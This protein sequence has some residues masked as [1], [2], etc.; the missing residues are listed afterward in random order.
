MHSFR[1]AGHTFRLIR[2]WP[3]ALAR[4]LACQQT[5]PLPPRG[6]ALSVNNQV[7]RK[8]LGSMRHHVCARR[9]A[10]E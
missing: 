1:L 8:S 2:T 7:R 9:A 6:E 5:W 3:L 10:H 4:C